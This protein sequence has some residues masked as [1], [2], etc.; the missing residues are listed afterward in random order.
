[1]LRRRR[2]ELPTTLPSTGGTG[3]YGAPFGGGASSSVPDGSGKSIKM[4]APLVKAIRA[5]SIATKYTYVWFGV[6]VLFIWSGWSLISRGS[7]SMILD[8][9]GSGCTLQISKPKSFIPR[10]S[11][12]SASSKRKVRIEFTK[13][14]LVRSDNILWDPDAQQ[15]V[16]NFGLSSPTYNDKEEEEMDY[17][18]RKRPNKQWKKHKKKKKKKFTSKLWG[19]DDNGNYHSYTLVLRDATPDLDEGG[20]SGEG[21]E[22]PSMKMARQMQQRH[23]AMMNDPNSLAAKLSQFSVHS[24]LQNDNS[25][26]YNLHLRDFNVAQT[27]RLA[28]TAVSKI[29][30]YAKGRRSS[31]TIREARPV[32]WQGLTLLILG[33]FSLIL[34]LLLG[35]FWE[36]YDSTKDGSYRK[37]MAE[38][39]R[40]KEMEAK[41]KISNRKVVTRTAATSGYE[42]RNVGGGSRLDRRSS[43]VGY[44]AAKRSM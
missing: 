3:G 27:R 25:L 11:N 16:E 43:G 42:G 38:I 21:D 14:Q 23:N 18:G 10:N 34:C 41:R 5:A 19:P 29:N 12:S 39:K 37:R 44:G 31:F 24:G 7:A 1:M 40:R 36:E 33:I 2:D 8:C 6:S 9:K 20:N 35:Q 22:S 30:A 32:S 26:E 17:E 13:D 15:I 28:R 4:D